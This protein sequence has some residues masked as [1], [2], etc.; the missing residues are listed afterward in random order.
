[1]ELNEITSLIQ[2]RDFIVETQ[3]NPAF[4]RQTVNYL[5]KTQL[6]IDKKIVALLQDQGFKD[7]INFADAQKALEEAAKNNNIKSGL[8][9]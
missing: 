1:M 7:Y 8:K 2:I 6:L 5:S 9:R 3:N 4:D